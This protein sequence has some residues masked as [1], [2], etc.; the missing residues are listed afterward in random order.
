MST[1]AYENILTH[2]H[3][4]KIICDQGLSE[5]RRGEKRLRVRIVGGEGTLLPALA[6][7]PAVMTADKTTAGPRERVRANPADRARLIVAPL[8]TQD[9]TCS[10]ASGKTDGE[11]NT[12]AGIYA[13]NPYR[14]TTTILHERS[15]RGEQ[16]FLTLFIPLGAHEPNPLMAV[17]QNGTDGAEVSFKDGSVLVVKREKDRLHA[18]LR[19]AAK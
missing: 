9:V 12:L 17:R 1:L 19:P 11:W 5:L 14:K 18:E 6:G 10:S 16:R 7:H 15:G 13:Q 4:G 3:H 8:F 2:I